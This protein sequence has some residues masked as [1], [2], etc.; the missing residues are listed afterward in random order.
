L[1]QNKTGGLLFLR[2]APAREP[3]DPAAGERGLDPAWSLAAEE[4][5]LDNP[6]AAGGLPVLILYENRG[7]LV[8]GKNQ[9]PWKE[10][11][12]PVLRGGSPEFYRRISGGGAVWHGPGN[13]NFAF[14]M[15]RGDFSKE[16][17]L[18]FVRRA[19]ARAGL[20]V[21]RTARGDLVC[22]G[23]K[24]SGNALAYHKNRVLHH[25]TLLVDADLRALRSCLPDGV[26]AGGGE[27]FI[28][29]RAVASVP[30]PVANL[31]DFSPGI[32]ALRIAEAFLEEARALYETV[33]VPENPETLLP[34][35]KLRPL[36]SRHETWEWKC[37]ATPAFVCGTAGAELYVRDGLICAVRIAGAEC[38]EDGRIGKRFSL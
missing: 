2:F 24:V 28:E 6:A 36:I 12:P 37:G 21:H 30:M 38:P 4:Y 31:K 20:R 1:S 9:N 34:P 25:G 8:I 11:A 27:F 19:L 18:D 32:T 17:N 13:L 3:S 33:E 35:E 7:A 26:R 23:E 29:T 14:I 15:P 5:L 16:E 22:G 10:I